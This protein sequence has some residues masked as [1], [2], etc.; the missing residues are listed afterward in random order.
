MFGTIAHCTVKPGQDAAF[1][2][3]GEEWTRERGSATGQVAECVFKLR[4]R[5]GEYMVVGIFANEQAYDSNAADPE[6]DHWYQKMRATLTDD[7]QWHDGE[8]THQTLFA[9][10]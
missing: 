9:G 10:I 3:V 6:T 2:Q 8:V 7:P 4:D 1:L 5:P